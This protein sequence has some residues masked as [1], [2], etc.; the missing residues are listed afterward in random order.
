MILIQSQLCRIDQSDLFIPRSRGGV[1]IN[2]AP[3]S[4]LSAFLFSPHSASLFPACLSSS[5]CARVY[6][7]YA[8]GKK[9][10]KTRRPSNQTDLC[11]RGN[12]SSQRRHVEILLFARML[13]FSSAVFVF[14]FFCLPPVSPPPQHHH[15]HRRLAPSTARHPGHV[16]TRTHRQVTKTGPDCPA[17]QWRRRGWEPS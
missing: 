11:A 12:L 8:A 4:P 9:K 2:P 1:E 7:T 10:R 5:G 15:K 13:C 6:T 14:L 16:K 3:P 17:H